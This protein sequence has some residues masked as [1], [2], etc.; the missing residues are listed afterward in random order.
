M[1]RYVAITAI[2]LLGAL[3]FPM[4]VPL[5]GLLATAGIFAAHGT[6]CVALLIALAAGGAIIGDTLG[7]ATGRL[8]MHLYRRRGMALDART[9]RPSDRLRGVAARVLASGVV[10]RAAGWCNG[11]LSRGGSM[12]AL[13]L[14]SRTVLGVFGPVINIL[15][16][17]AALP[18]Q[19]ISPL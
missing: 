4:P 7:Y 8:G 1:D 19:P 12:A 17:G 6:F 14:L 5:A 10:T 3:G 11:R 16:R 15:S 18:A 13:I 2:I 9:S